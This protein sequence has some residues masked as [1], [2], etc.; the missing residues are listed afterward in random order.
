VSKGRTRAT[1]LYALSDDEFIE[2][3]A[4]V[5]SCPKIAKAFNISPWSVETRLKNLGVDRSNSGMPGMRQSDSHLAARS[6]AIVAAYARDGNNRKGITRSD[7]TKARMSVAQKL[8]Y[9][10]GTKKPV[11]LDDIGYVVESYRG[12]LMR[13]S[14]E[15]EYAKYLD[16]L[17]I[18]WSYEPEALV[19]PG[20]CTYFPD[21]YI[22]D[23]D[24]YVEVKG[25][26]RENS[27][28]KFDMIRHYFSDKTF[29]VED[30]K[31]NWQIKNW[32]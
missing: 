8:A 17:E 19:I 21:F 1:I 6:S 10:T 26:W 28:E 11:V 14:W 4:T 5:K 20:I 27:R 22:H 30:D 24:F 25:Y 3:Y 31:T 15:I 32:I 9:A 13:S 23:F 12:N 29:H 18:S 2:L 16:S 7:E